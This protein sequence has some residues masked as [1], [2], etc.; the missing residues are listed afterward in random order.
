L[1]QAARDGKRAAEELRLAPPLTGDSA[2][3]WYRIRVRPLERPGRPIAT[4]WSVADVTRE[5]AR[6]ENVFQELQHAINFLDHAPAGFFSCDQRGGVTYINATL[7]DWLDYD[8]A[9][10]GSGGLKLA[11]VVP[12]ASAAL[13]SSMTGQ[14][15]EVRTEQFDVDMKRR[16]GQS[17]PVR[18]IHRVAFAQDRSPGPSRTLVLNRAPGLE[19]SENLRAAEVR[20]ARFFNQT[21]MAI[22]VVDAKGVIIRSNAAFARLMPE[23]LTP[24]DGVRSLFAGALPTSCSSRRNEGTM[25]FS[26]ARVLNH[27]CWQIPYWSIGL[28]ATAC[29][30]APGTCSPPSE[31]ARK[32]SR[33]RNTWP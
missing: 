2:V 33:H 16:N 8:L 17:L 11:D 10:V 21:P 7:A 25:L 30:T 12:G 13:F 28:A 1:S 3:A 6:H 32:P 14:P 26:T 5:R 29:E 24:S 31:L 4:L 9:Q 20:F 23:A 18:I 15:G 27:D 19:P 22:A